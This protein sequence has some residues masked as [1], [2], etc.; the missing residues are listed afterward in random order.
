[1]RDHDEH[2]KLKVLYVFEYDI[3]RIQSVVVVEQEL[4]FPLENGYTLFEEVRDSITLEPTYVE[5]V[6]LLRD[7]HV[8][9]PMDPSHDENFA[10][11]NHLGEL[12]LSPTSYTSIFCNI[13]NEV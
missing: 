6:T 8:P 13:H 7:M 10:L 4:E 9:T 11:S 12:V 2:L 5:S 3:D 1:M